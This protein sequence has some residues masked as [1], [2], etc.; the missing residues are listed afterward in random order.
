[1]NNYRVQITITESDNPNFSSGVKTASPV[2]G[3]LFIT[4]DVTGKNS[5][6]MWGDLQ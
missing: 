2:S 1:M 6:E 5:I 4:V 3:G